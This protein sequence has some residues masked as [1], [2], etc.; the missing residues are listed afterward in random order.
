MWW[1]SL[2]TVFQAFL[3]FE[4]GL[5]FTR[6]MGRAKRSLCLG[7]SCSQLQYFYLIINRIIGWLFYLL[8]II[9]SG[10]GILQLLAL[11]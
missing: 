3:L 7:K 5:L 11:R 6:V 9:V 2:I 1:F 4:L 8:A 10:L